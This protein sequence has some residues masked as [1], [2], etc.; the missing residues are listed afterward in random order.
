MRRFFLLLFWLW[1]ADA[2]QAAITIDDIASKPSSRARDFLIWEFLR[3]KGVDEKSAKAAFALVKNKNNIRLKRAYA[4]IVDDEVRKELQ[5]KK[6]KDLL[7]IVDDKCLQVA[8]SLYKTINYS[9]FQRDQ[10]LLHDLTPKQKIL[11]S[12][13]NEP[14]SFASYRYYEPKMVIV[15]LKSIPKKTLQKQ[16]DQKLDADTME[17]LQSAPNFGS[18]VQLVVTDYRLKNLQHSLLQT[19]GKKLDASTNFFLGLNALRCHDKKKALEFL[20][21]ARKKARY[22]IPRDKADFWLYLTTKDRSYLQTLLLSMSINIYT[23]YAHEK[24]HV[25]V[26]NYFTKL[27][28]NKK[29][30]KYDLKDPFD[31]LAI[32]EDIHK[33]NPSKLFDLVKRY[34]NYDLL[35]VQRFVLERAYDFKMHGYIMPYDKE[36][37]RLG[38]EDKALVYAIM[39]QESNYIPSGISRSFAL[40]L[41]QL[42]PFLVDHIAKKRHEKLRSYSEMFKPE[43]NLRYAWIHLQWLKRVL[44]DNPLFIAYAYN[45]GYGFFKRYKNS[46]RFGKGE[47]EPYMS[48]E[49]MRNSESRE[50]AKRVLAN[51]VM[52]KK[53]YHDDFSLISFFET[54]K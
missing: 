5:C 38:I 50:Y 28:T 8:F 10:L 4:K 48:M 26:E 31:W 40:G 54:L 37:R 14:Y 7:D 49:M 23:L 13:Q 53:I 42:M 21:L 46:K 51:Y 16:L 11:L 34:Q 17:F 6:R 27:V 45:G 32:L 47:Y 2:L 12:L 29:K 15:Y 1:N 41:M 22:P 39:R 30:S 18:F 9:R 35:P 3:Q 19:N 24:M 52:Y 25:S 20:K 36:L 43:K 44:H 33:T